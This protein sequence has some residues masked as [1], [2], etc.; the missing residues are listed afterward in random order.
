MGLTKWDVT[1]RKTV[2]MTIDA[3]YMTIP[4]PLKLLLTFGTALN[5]LPSL[6]LLQPQLAL[7]CSVRQI[8]FR[9]HLRQSSNTSLSVFSRNGNYKK[10]AL[11]DHMRL[12]RVSPGL[13]LL[14]R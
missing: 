12:A 14:G 6:D 11:G 13:Q 1:S 9:R 2:V 5:T 7:Q 4:S 8:T 3:K 10:S